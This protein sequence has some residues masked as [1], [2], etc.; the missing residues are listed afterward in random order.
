MIEFKKV[1]KNYNKKPILK[2][3][4]LKIPQYKTTILVGTS[5]CGKSTLLRLIVG[6]ICPDGGNVEFD[7]LNIQKSTINQIR[8]KIGYVIQSGGLFPHISARRNITLAAEFNKWDQDRINARLSKLSEICK[9]HES[10][11]LKYPKH[12]SGGQRQ[13]VNLMR[14]LMMDP[15][16]LLLDEPLGALDPITR[17]ELQDELKELFSSLQKTVVFVTHDIGEAFYLG[18]EIALMREG[19]ILQHS[20]PQELLD[21][22]KDPFVTK[23]L[24]SQR[25]LKRGPV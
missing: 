11:L 19:T 18:D 12:L 16:V 3:I 6:L 7:S 10:L 13:R 9:I 5:G 20:T 22:P 25:S 1:K 8:S 14:A 4:N 15:D 21:Q 24:L 23:F 17:V 2:D